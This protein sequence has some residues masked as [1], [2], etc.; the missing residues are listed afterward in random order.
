MSLIG[1]QGLIVMFGPQISTFRNCFCTGSHNSIVNNSFDVTNSFFGAPSGLG[2]HSGIGVHSA[3][4][5]VSFFLFDIK[6][7][8][9]LN[10]HCAYLSFVTQDETRFFSFYSSFKIS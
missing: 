9:M 3:I 2:V 8:S 4:F 5:G 7:A 10:Q 1:L 6:L